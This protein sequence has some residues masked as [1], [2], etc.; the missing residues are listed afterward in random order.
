MDRDQ[1]V[2]LE[3]IEISFTDEVVQHQQATNCED[4]EVSL[5]KDVQQ[6]HLNKTC[7]EEV[8]TK[9]G[10]IQSLEEQVE[11]KSNVRK[12]IRYTI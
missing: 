4:V 2:A 12:L 10:K 1:A 9:D 7:D 11:N 6:Q 8:L 3:N 5:I